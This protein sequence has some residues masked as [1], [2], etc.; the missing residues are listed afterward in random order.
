LAD[1][2]GSA[3]QPCGGIEE[4]IILEKCQKSPK[5]PWKSVKKI[6]FLSWIM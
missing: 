1:L 5:F 3:N 6:C 2:E 4:G